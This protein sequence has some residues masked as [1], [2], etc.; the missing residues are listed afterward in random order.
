LIGSQGQHGIGAALIVAELHFEDG[1]GQFFNDCAPTS[2]HPAF[3]STGRYFFNILY[4]WVLHRT[5]EAVS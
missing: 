5:K 4:L 3:R 1:G 2:K